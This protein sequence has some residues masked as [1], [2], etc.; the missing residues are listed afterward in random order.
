MK[1]R[2][3]ATSQASVG[4]I[5]V[6]GLAT[7]LNLV[8][9]IILARSLGVREYGIYA[10]AIAAAS[11]LAIPSRAPLSTLVLREVAGGMAREQP[12]L[13]RGVMRWTLR[14]AL[15]LSGVLVA[16][17]AII[18]F[19]L[20]DRLADES[21][22]TFGLALLL[23]PLFSLIAIRSATL[24]GL[25]YVVSGQIPEQIVVP[26]V[27]VVTTGGL[28]AVGQADRLDAAGAILLNIGAVAV[29]LAVATWMLARRLPAGVRDSPAE[30]DRRAWTSATWPLLFVSGFGFANREMGLI[31]VGSIAGPVGAGI[32]RVAV[33]GADLVAFALAGINAAI[34][35]RLAQ[36]HAVNDIAGLRRVL[37]FGAL[38]SLAWAVPVAAVLIMFGDR[39]LTTVFGVEFAAGAM[40]LTILCI[41]Q[42]FH[43]ATGP[44]GQLLNMTGRE[45]ATAR[46]HA[47][48]LMVALAGGLLLI[49]R[50]GAEGAAVAT[51]L[52]VV[53]WN[54]VV[55]IDAAK[56]LG[57]IAGNDR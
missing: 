43:S 56:A 2:F 26:A 20:S 16:V 38:A 22:L 30:F 55:S 8:V 10:F 13:V 5:A 51:A 45:R 44:I 9:G 21:R 12:G 49:P 18:G 57:L 42:V 47:I 28:L 24:R 17:A 25:H 19:G 6:R 36:L 46:G 3:G 53:T 11:M 50:W 52:S 33:R 31:L 1:R 7:V 34:A 39:I 29:A 48:A 35:P 15:V 4:S 41:G 23:V 14:R 32:Y 54:A 40:T 27:M 37:L